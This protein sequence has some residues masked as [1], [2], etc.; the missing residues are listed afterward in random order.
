MKYY[1]RILL[2][3]YALQ[4]LCMNTSSQSLTNMSEPYIETKTYVFE[5]VNKTTSLVFRLVRDSIVN[6]SGYYYSYNN[7]LIF[8]DDTIDEESLTV[9]NTDNIF[10]EDETF[11][12]EIV[13]SI[14]EDEETQEEVDGFG[15]SGDVVASGTV[16]DNI[17]WKITGTEGKYNLI[18]LGEG[19]M[20]NFS[21][22][23]DAPWIAYKSGIKTVT[24]GRGI[25]S[26]GGYAF[27]VCNNVEKL[28]LPDTLTTIGWDAFR[29]CTMLKS[30]TLP[31]SIKRIY[32]GAFAQCSQLDNVVLPSNL[33]IL[34]FENI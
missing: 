16:G 22:M 8:E 9:E 1:L 4:S 6:L 25:T 28:E 24:I 10:I 17:T 11:D 3:I 20:D 34:E 29:Y 30:I 32:A 33:S 23:N 18:L 27:C 26:I 15:E 19:E 12:T 13:D 7:V 2:L 5:G 21:N 14:F 31:N